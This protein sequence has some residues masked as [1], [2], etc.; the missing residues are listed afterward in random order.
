MQK[1]V[2]IKLQEVKENHLLEGGSLDGKRHR[3]GAAVRTDDN[4]G[5]DWWRQAGADTSRG[6][7]GAHT[8]SLSLPSNFLF[9]L[10]GDGKSV[11]MP[12][13]E[14]LLQLATES[15]SPVQI[16]ATK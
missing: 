9:L 12:I 8:L 7:G 10:I 16:L 3:R 4:S 5:N 13:K 1:F 14:I 6:G 2:E 11:S 15:P